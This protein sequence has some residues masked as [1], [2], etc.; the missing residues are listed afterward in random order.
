[1]DARFLDQAKDAAAQGDWGRAY[2]LL[3]DGRNGEPLRSAEVA[4]LA[5]MA[6]A[7]GHLDETIGTW[8]QAYSESMSEGD[9]LSAAGAAVRVAMHLLFDTAMMAP[10]RGWTKRAE[11]LLAGYDETPAHAWMAV[12]RS[13]ERLLSGDLPEAKKWAQEAV[14]VGSTCDSAAAAIGQMAQA[15]HRMIEGEIEQGLSL[16]NEAAV[17]TVSGELDPVSTGVVYC[18]LVC[19]LQGMALYDLAEEWTTAM[20][21]W[22]HG[23]PVGSIHGRCRI[24]RAEILRLRGACSDA[25]REALKACEELRPYLRR[26]FGWPL[27]ELGRI[28]LQKGDVKRAEQALRAALAAGWD[29]EPWLAYIQLVKG[30]TILALESVSNALDRPNNVPSKELPPTTELRRAPLLSAKVE[31]AVQAGDLDLARGAA[32]ELSQIAVMYKSK[33]FLANAATARGQVALAERHPGGALSFFGEAVSLWN[34]VGAPYEMALARMGL[35]ESHLA[36]GN[37]G[38]AAKE[39]EAA[40]ATFERI[41]AAGQ[42][43]KATKACDA[44][45]VH[46]SGHQLPSSISESLFRREGDYWSVAFDG[47]TVRLRDRKGLHYLRTLLASPGREFHVLNLVS[48]ESGESV[49]HPVRDRSVVVSLDLDAGTMLDSQAK[50]AYRRRLDE[51]GEDVEEARA[52]G[53]HERA[54]QAEVERDFLVRE[55]S[56]AVGIG[57]RDRRAGSASERARASVT[58]AVRHSIARIREYHPGLGDHLDRTVRTG[59]YCS[60]LPDPRMPQVWKV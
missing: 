22:R 35:A 39:Y 20:E 36:D 2:E 4:F 57:G 50:D 44:L 40:R 49:D 7:S 34:Q 28:W 41:G 18:E 15:R 48:S 31:I 45:R 55:L 59:T 58:R 3:I 17:A 47:H 23:Q 26:E 42:A 54:A 14:D 8:E 30:E 5:D 13:F 21:N 37:E 56:R 6:Y 25:E 12:V 43:A 60:Y 9:H 16:L 24:H 53:D 52:M 32:D 11:K 27:T 19:A 46:G 10:V 51:I 38:I 33:A 1:M 29:P